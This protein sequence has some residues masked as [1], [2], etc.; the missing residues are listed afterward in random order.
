ML[1]IGIFQERSSGLPVDISSYD[2]TKCQKGKK[3]VQFFPPGLL[4]LFEICGVASLWGCRGAGPCFSPAPS[5]KTGSSDKG[6]NHEDDESEK[7][8]LVNV[9]IVAQ[10]GGG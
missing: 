1:A 9:D 7:R 8:A 4:V 10:G 3:E 2:P 6:S 5:A